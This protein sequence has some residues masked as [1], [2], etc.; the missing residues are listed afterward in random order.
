M[1]TE[2]IPVTTAR[3]SLPEGWLD[4]INAPNNGRGDKRL[5]VE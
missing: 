4:M 5:I 3:R 2:S 1:I